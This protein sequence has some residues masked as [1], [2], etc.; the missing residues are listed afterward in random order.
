MV[1]YRVLWGV[2]FVWVIMLLK[3]VYPD[4]QIIQL[5][6]LLLSA[7]G[8]Y[9]IYRQ[10]VIKR[11]R[12]MQ[13]FKRDNKSISENEGN[14]LNQQNDLISSV[15]ENQSRADV[16]VVTVAGVT[17]KNTFIALGVQLSGIL[18]G[19]GNIVIEGLIEG[20]VSGTHQVRVEAGGQVKGDIRASHIVI[21]GYAEGGLYADAITLQREGKIKGKINTDELIIEKGG[22]FI[23]TSQLQKSE[24]AKVDTDNVM[25]LNM[26]SQNNRQ[27]DEKI[28]MD[29][30]IKPEYQTKKKKEG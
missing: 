23:G 18:E 17:R 24:V 26:Q 13:I 20:N 11:G 12:K 27:F 4:V 15:E 3:K 7:F 16:S 21:N 30:L 8:I 2:W 9:F 5:A 29:E 10:L 14:S 22:I 6:S 25:S 28:I 1:F 19:Q